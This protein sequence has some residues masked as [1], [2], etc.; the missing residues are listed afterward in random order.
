MNI[1]VLFYLISMLLALILFVFLFVIFVELTKKTDRVF[2]L[3]D[4]SFLKILAASCVWPV[5]VL[6]MAFMFLVECTVLALSKNK[7]VKK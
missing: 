5:T 4:I 6:W 3:Q 2:A 7:G 1:Y